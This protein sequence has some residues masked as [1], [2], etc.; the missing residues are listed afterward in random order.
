MQKQLW[1][2]FSSS[3][4]G[5]ELKMLW[6]IIVDD[7]IKIRINV[8]KENV[9]HFKHV[10]K[11]YVVFGLKRSGHHGIIEWMRQ[12]LS[13]DTIFY[14]NLYDL[15]MHPHYF[16]SDITW[17]GIRQPCFNIEKDTFVR[18]TNLPDTFDKP[19]EN[20]I[21]SFEDKLIEDYNEQD[22][23]TMVKTVTDSYDHLIISV[24]S[25][26]PFNT[27]AS[28]EIGN[29]TKARTLM[30]LSHQEFC[31]SW[32]IYA[33][34]VLNKSLFEKGVGVDY[35]AWILDKNNYRKK[36]AEELLL[37][38]FNIDSPTLVGLNSSYDNNKREV[39]YY[40]QDKN[41][42]L[43]RYKTLSRDSFNGLVRDKNLLLLSVKLYG[44]EFVQQILRFFKKKNGW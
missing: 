28:K 2:C 17:K 4:D 32:K 31:D 18:K 24:M 19:P 27:Y 40:A 6:W 35:N 10:N 13:D 9:L 7:E 22:I 36:K 3:Q 11:V 29:K 44:K 26:D 16:C 23:E 38:S 20:I 33:E 41:K 42:F 39:S 5:Y 30:N 12:N 43:E 14:N 15:G 37:D 21:I 8:A 34:Q 1:L 25:R